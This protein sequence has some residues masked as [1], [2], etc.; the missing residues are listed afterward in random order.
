MQKDFVEYKEIKLVGIKVP[1]SFTKECEL[2]SSQIF[3]CVIK[4][5]HEKLF[6][7]ISDR[8]KVGVTY[9]VYTDYESDYKGN[10]SYFI[11]EEVTSLDNVPNDFFTLSIPEQHYVK[12]TTDPGSMPDVV[13]GAWKKIWEM[14]PKDLGGK[15][16]YIADF[17]IYDERAED[18]ENI[19]LDIFVG[20]E[21]S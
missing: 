5:F 20:I 10:Y 18:H 2:E 19:V 4:Y 14:S 16:K 21:K 6:D 1:T 12:Y 15:R 9:C 13:K 8:K 7:K 11:G 3:P 17:E